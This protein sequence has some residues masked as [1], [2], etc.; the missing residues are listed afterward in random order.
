[1]NI[2]SI[3]VMPVE[4]YRRYLRSFQE[5]VYLTPTGR[6]EMVCL[7]TALD[8]LTAETDNVDDTLSNFAA[9]IKL[10]SLQNQCK[11]FFSLYY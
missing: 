2:G 11:T 9:S 4:H 10:L 5:F 8:V 3:L 1:M 7:T 6:E